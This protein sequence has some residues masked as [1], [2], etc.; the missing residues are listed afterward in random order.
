[1]TTA[2]GPCRVCG[3]TIKACRVRATTHPRWCCPRCIHESTHEREVTDVNTLHENWRLFKRHAPVGANLAVGQLDGDCYTCHTEWPCSVWLEAVEPLLAERERV[4]VERAESALR[5]AADD[6][7]AR[8]GH[9]AN[10]INPYR[11]L[12]NEIEGK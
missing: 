3:S 8:V 11:D 2:V 1:M 5:Q 6:F 7:D 12:L 10:G 4:A 9:V